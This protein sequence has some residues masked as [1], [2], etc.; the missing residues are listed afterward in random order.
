MPNL[1]TPSGKWMILSILVFMSACKWLGSKEQ[2][3]PVNPS[4]TTMPSSNPIKGVYF[5]DWA[6]VDSLEKKGLYK[7]A[8]E[9]VEAI[10]ARAKAENKQ[11][12]IIKAI[13]FRGKYITRLEEDGFVKA[14]Q[15]LEAEE[16]SARVQPEKALL[17]SILGQLYATFLS[18]QGW[19]ITERTPIPDG[20]GG[21]ILTWSA[22]QIEKRALELYNASV[23]DESALSAIPTGDF[24]DVISSGQNDSI[25][26]A[27]LRPTLYDLLAHRAIDHF[28]NERNYLTEPAYAFQLDQEKA[29]ADR[30]VF[31]KEAFASQDT[32]SGK[33]LALHLFQDLL[34]HHAATNTGDAQARL[35]RLID[36]DLKRL[37]F[38]FANSVREDKNTLYVKALEGLHE[39]A[40]NHPSQSEIAYQ[41]ASFLFYSNDQDKV[42]NAKKA[43]ALCEEAIRLHPGSYGENWCRQ[44][45]AQMK[46]TS[47]DITVEQVS[48]PEKS[49]LVQ[50]SFRNLTRAYVKVVR[51]NSDNPV[52]INRMR[53][54]E[55][56]SYLL[57]MKE[58][59]QREWAIPDP[60]DYQQHTTELALDGLPRGYYWVLV[61]DNPSFSEQGGHVSF[62]S[63][64]V[65]QLAVIQANENGTPSVVV[66]D[67]L[68][69]A[70][71]EGVK[72]EYYLHYYGG[73]VEELR[74][75]KTTVTNKD[76]WGEAE[77]L[78]NGN[79]EVRAIYQQDTLWAGDVMNYRYDDGQEEFLQTRFFTDRKLY[80]PGQQIYFKGILYKN[81][82]QGKPQIIPN[83][84]V[85]VKLYDVNQQDKATVTLRS[86]E[87][88]SFNGV[89]TAPASGLTGLMNIHCDEASGAEFFSVEEYKRPRFEVTMKP[90]EGAYRVGDRITVKG[91]AKNYAGNV[92]DGAALRYRVVRQARFPFWDWGWFRKPFPPVAEM[93]IASGTLVTGA[94]G[95]FEIPFE[96]IP[97]KSVSKKDQPV[98]DY[99]VFVDVTDI[100]GETRSNSTQVSAG[101]S[102]LQISWNLTD[103]MV[104]DSMARVTLSATNMSGR[105][106]EA[107]GTINIQ[108]LK[109][110][111][112]FYKN[113]YWERPDLPTITAP[114]WARM[115]PDI[116]RKN[117]DDPENWE[118]DGPSLTVD[119]NTTQSS[120]ADLHRNRMTSGYYTI[121]LRSKDKYGEEVVV[122]KTVRV[123][124]PKKPETR[125]DQPNVEVEKS[126]LEPGET[127]RFWMGG[128]A[129]NLHF[130]LSRESNGTMVA[131]RWFSVN[132]A[133]KTEIPVTE[134]DRGGF[135]VHWFA[136]YN[137]RV[138]G[139]TY[140][141]LNVPWSNKDLQITY[142]TFRDKLSPGQKE[143]WRLKISGPK[144]DKVAAEMVAAMYDA[145]L[146][147]FAPHSWERIAFPYHNIKLS[148]SANSFAARSGEA[149]QSGIENYPVQGRG[150]PQ[151]N[152][153]GFP[154]W[155]AYE[156]NVMY[157]RAQPM[158]D[159]APASAPMAAGGKMRKSNVDTVVT[160]DPETYEEKVQIVR[161]DLNLTADELQNQAA[162]PAP[163][164]QNGQPAPRRNLNETVFFFPELRTDKDGNIVLKFT[165]NEALTRWKLLTFAHTKSLEQAISVKEVVTQKELMVI[166][167]PPRFLRA[168]DSF[169][170][171]AKVSNLSQQVIQG[172][173]T[174]NL[175]DA[176]TLKPV[177]AEFELTDKNNS[178]AF[179]IQPGQSAPL[180]WKVKIPEDFAG[181][182]TWQIFADGNKFRDGEE[183]SLPV[184]SNRMLVTET[185]PITV[186]GNQTKSFVF[187]NFKNGG[188]S[189]SLV[190]HRYTIEF[191]SNPVWYA[192]QALPYIM[193]YPHECSEQIFSRFYANTLATSV[194]TK[195]PQIKRVYD[196]WKGTDAMKSNLEKNQELKS[197][198][199]EETPWVLDAQIEQQQKQN[200][201]L[202]FDLN[203]MAS[204][205][206]RTLAILAERQ[207]ENGAWAWFPGGKD[208]WYITQHIVTGFGHLGKLGAFEAKNDQT[209]SPMLDKAL[210]Y[211]DRKVIEQYNE[212][213]R[214]VKMGKAKWEDDHLDGM[215]IQYLYARS[216][217]K[218]D[219]PGKEVAYYLGQAEKFWLGKGIYQE[220]LIALALHRN[221]RGVA[222]DIVKSLRERAIMKEELGMYWPVSW[223]YYWY[224]LPVETQALMVEVFS[225]VSNDAKS[226]EELRIWLLKNKQT[227]RWES[228]KATAEAVYALLLGTGS[229]ENWLNNNQPVQVSLGGKTLKPAETE[230]GTGYFKEQWTG[231]EVKPSWSKI[232]VKNPN[233]NIVW[234]AAYWQYF[235]DLDKIKDFQ[236][237]PLTIVKQL[238]TEENSPT[239][240]ILKPIKEGTVLH[241]G[242]KIKVRIEIRVDREMEF[243]HLKDM[244]A[245]GFEPI[246]VL[247]SYKWQ[248]GLGY[249][250]STKDLATNFFIDYLPRGT[251]VFEYP[252]VVSHRGDMSNGITTMQ[253]M[254]AP[255]FTSH[256][257]GVRVKVE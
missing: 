139:P 31:R 157:S 121:T 84:K 113:R 230:V 209:T 126:T 240:P 101:Y 7:S 244:R 204:E 155:S 232:E 45:L 179:N 228:T 74:L 184:V 154:M 185:L 147:Q 158:M 231:K 146:D 241:R 33:L 47:L 112:I 11:P 165:M 44:L 198:L 193:E 253:C 254:Y 175:L 226:V 227:N 8:L 171:A 186:R 210:G 202:L 72:L 141:S 28:M 100:S 136:V 233:S 97:D 60:G 59:Q 29:F 119:F 57:K 63:F 151:I 118:K 61:S 39:S 150:Y 182:V 207:L 52:I 142:E 144:K 123:I 238:F 35:S 217:Y 17:Q 130:L 36:I 91:E 12:Q 83:Y 71:L 252:L 2:P 40:K 106:Q 80:R 208:S 92:V 23:S 1:R 250:E 122:K 109:E 131:P 162:P 103:R 86:N 166:S 133:G 13:L 18:Q 116:A 30:D 50:L 26:N 115:F 53:W 38:V 24:E 94:D 79:L 145:S 191:T 32:S 195:M 65:S 174:L 189:N 187:D 219:R 124:D 200:I 221:G 69:G 224:Q 225:E 153:W 105:P 95:G 10:E 88:G 148:L 62:A 98:F 125:F 48:L 96:A 167:N 117:E 203:R 137:N 163:P 201:A 220:G 3:S 54:E 196:R 160:F 243:V 37:Q 99:R 164:E 67:R 110:P 5:D 132:G 82:A 246:N 223:G 34:R 4:T 58:V 251:F 234:G 176:A 42:Q 128:K 9:K 255:E 6:V 152:W 46:A 143:E 245:A 236:K 205:R 242:D 156:R 237:T 235:E 197:A 25:A 15:V 257:K 102:A 183:S 51:N 20:E 134:V 56:L 213:E 170:F 248:G 239:G 43:V 173:A 212:L 68:S 215:I 140:L 188:N 214:Q 55:R 19:N 27:A 89:F 41:L 14:I 206:E 222:N 66:T 75:Q 114:D 161:N 192:V 159:A 111:S 93:E 85:T 81:D 178:T 49:S 78:P 218:V 149:H 73:S 194:V 249:Y 127:A 90:V 76:G 87:Y 190:T 216:F 211:C 21:D 120:V 177:G 199:L 16:K 256:S 108:R 180:A 181:A 129:P 104:I 22:A 247:S 70:P 138:Y 168:G 172:K 169:E 229:Q 107:Q 77:N 64:A 135:A